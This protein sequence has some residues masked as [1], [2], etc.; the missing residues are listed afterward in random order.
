MSIISTILSQFFR[1]LDRLIWV[2]PNYNFNC[3]ILHYLRDGQNGQKGQIW[4]SIV[5]TVGDIGIFRHF[6]GAVTY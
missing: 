1:S 5:C 3:F 2:N 6:R 4:P